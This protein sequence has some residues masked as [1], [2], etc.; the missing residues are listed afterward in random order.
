[1]DHIAHVSLSG[2]I[3]KTFAYWRGRSGACYVH[4]VYESAD[5][6]GYADAVYLVVRRTGARRELI[7]VGAT[8]T[9]P[10]LFFLGRRYA[11]ALRRGGNE[12]HVHVP[13]AEGLCPEAVARDIEAAH[14][15]E[16]VPAGTS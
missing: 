15:V 3:E 1:M 10:D 9:F 7:A 2:Q 5:A 12:V 13:A 8:G 16:P 14:A 4:S 11:A 6:P